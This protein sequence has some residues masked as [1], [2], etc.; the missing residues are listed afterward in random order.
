MLEARQVAQFGHESHG[1][2]GLHAA[3]GLQ[4]FD[5]GLP[6]TDGA[7]V[8]DLGVV[9]FGDISHGTRVFV[10]IHSDVQCARLVQG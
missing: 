3:Q 2:G 1:H 8:D 6:G 10:D 9:V 7:E 5:V 4:G